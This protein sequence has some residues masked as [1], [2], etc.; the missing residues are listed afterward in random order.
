MIHTK[1]LIRRLA[2]VP[3]LLAFGLV[4][5]WAGEAAAQE[6]RLSVDKTEVREDGGPVTIKVTAKTYNADGDHAAL[7]VE[8][9]VQ[10]KATAPF[11]LVSGPDSGTPQP[12]LVDGFGRRFTM[13]L[14]TIVIP[15]DQ[16]EVSVESIF[17]PIPTNHENDPTMT[18]GDNQYKASDRIP[19]EDSYIFLTGDSGGAVKVDPDGSG[20]EENF[21]PIIM[22]DANS[23]STRI[24]L[25]L[26]PDK[27][28]KEAGRT[29]VTVEGRL[30]GAKVNQPLSFLLGVSP[31]GQNSGTR[32]GRDADYDIELSTLTIPRKKS[33]GS[34]TIHI[35]P[36]NAG[37]GFIR[38]GIGGS[39]PNIQFPKVTGVDI[40]RDG[41]SRDTWPASIPGAIASDPPTPGP[42]FTASE[43][44]TLL[45]ANGD[46]D[47]NDVFIVP[48]AADYDPDGTD[49]DITQSE[50]DALTDPP[51][52]SDAD[53]PDGDSYFAYSE[54]AVGDNGWDINFD[55]DTD[56]FFK[57]V[58]EKDVPKYLSI[59]IVDFEITDTALAATKGL[60]ASP[61]EIRESVVGQTEASREVSVKLDI[62]LENALPNDTRVRF[63]VRDELT[64]LADD[65]IDGAQVATRGTHY[66][67]TVDDLVIPADSTKA[68]TTLNLVIF[69]DDGRND[70]R[71]FRVEAKVGTVSKYVGIKI[72]DDETTTTNITLSADPG[73]IKAE[74]G[75]QTITITGDLNGDVFEEDAKITLVIV[76]SDDKPAV[77]D[78]EYT[79]ALH[80]LTIP[81]GATSGSTTVTVT[82]LKGGDKKVW[83]GSVKNDPYAKNIDDDDILVSPVAVVLKDADETDEEDDPGAL[84]FDVDLSST[85]YDGSVGAAIDDIELPEATGGDGDRT[86]SVSNT[87]PAGL[88]FDADDL[89]ITGTP[90]AAGETTVVYT[91]IDAEG[92][93]ATTFTIEIA[94]EAPPTVSVESLNV[95]RT[96]VREDDVATEITLTAKLAA[97]APVA[98]AITFRLDGGTAI[99]DVDYTATLVGSVDLAE[100]DTEAQTTLLLTP[101]DNDE[102]DGDRIVGLRASAS[103]GSE[104]AE[105]TIADDETA[106][107][108][109]SLSADPHSVS[110]GAE[111]V[112]GQITASLSGKV[113][114]ADAVVTVT[115][116]E[117][118]STAARDVD[119]NISFS[120]ELTIPAGEVSGSIP[121]VIVLRTD[122]DDE[123]SETVALSGAIDALEDGTGTITINDADAMMEEDMIMALMFAEGAMIDAIEATAGT[124]IAE[125]VL[126]EATV[127]EG[128]ITYSVSD[129]LPAGLAFDA[130]TRTLSGTPEVATDGAVEVT[131]TA[132]AGDATVTLPISITVNAALEFDLSSFF[133]AFNGAGKV[134]PTTSHDLAEIREFIVGQR[135]EGIVLPAASGGTAPRTY[136]LSPALPAGLTFDA[137]T[138]TIAGTPRAAAETAYT[139]TVTDAS[140]AT[141]ALLVQTLPTAFSLADNFPNPFNP[142]TTIK[143]ALPQAA[144]VELTV[145]NV[146]G[147]PVRTL[148]AE[149][150]NAGR[151]VLEWD[152]TNDSGYSLSSGM[153]FYRLQAGGE[154]H[155]VKKM[156]LLK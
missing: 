136:S 128:D 155:E 86:Y 55:G 24:S 30:N 40:N 153:Y 33:L 66:T 76:S 121:F 105:V 16:K 13:T 8:R 46:G 50:Y 79:A 70:A 87:L 147:Q 71:V 149:H 32:A 52:G 93:A 12:D 151:Y 117:A 14:P 72:A 73:E 60:T 21:I 54:A 37:T 95:S 134:V 19:N 138:R 92:S 130:E 58:R 38:I 61:A 44:T 100:G 82:A 80:S 150:Q 107:T 112:R 48:E 77:R 83:I 103:G 97:A 18:T 116:D 47:F 123:G 25:S 69:D 109:I 63:F 56:D 125:V 11:R 124:A 34:A 65:F 118:A 62:E 6:V 135:V 67:A 68:S 126:P 15:K 81:A 91:V 115:I 3:W 110:E 22:I 43:Y 156:L 2:Y 144:D 20:E 145:Y 35:T 99:R 96:S 154:F 29:A 140:G 85:V 28:S 5:G 64:Q 41:D 148:V 104:A 146:V 45:D 53:D 9:V 23:P 119:Y 98:E 111:S 31:F 42:E 129:N 88:S 102:E 141:A 17:T 7:G 152:A 139:Y 49:D 90:T 1:S 51:E 143:Y 113:L 78:T 10:L 120:P 27:I 74:S 132:T 94:A 26:S 122:D 133:G 4:L 75:E 39:F 127:G 131:Y 59:R 108:S 36:K 84:S 142:T 89:T 57:V 137:A 101:L 114:D 106:S